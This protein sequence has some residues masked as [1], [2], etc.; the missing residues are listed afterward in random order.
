MR[1]I[2]FK[3]LKSEKGIPYSRPQLYRLIDAKRFPRPLPIGGNR[4]A[5][6]ESEL[7][8]WLSA[9]QEERD[10]EVGQAER[11]ARSEQAAKRAR[12]NSDREAA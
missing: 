7:D 3:D 5:F 1:I 8:A 10:S 11:Q 4:V 9:K 12:G 2:S 6:L